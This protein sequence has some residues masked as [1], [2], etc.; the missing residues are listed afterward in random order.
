MGSGDALSDSTLAGWE[1][2]PGGNG[3]ACRES[4][5]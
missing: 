4:S 3:M 5:A 2:K 1:T